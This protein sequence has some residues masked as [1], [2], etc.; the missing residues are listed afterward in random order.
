[1]LYKSWR[2]VVLLLDNT[3]TPLA[4]SVDDLADE[5]KRVL[6]EK[7]QK[8]KEL[9]EKLDQVY[10]LH[11][12]IAAELELVRHESKR[13]VESLQAVLTE[14]NANVAKAMR[15][16]G[17]TGKDLDGL[18][19]RAK[20]SREQVD[21]L[22]EERDEA[23]A[24]CNELRR[25]ADSAETAVESAQEERDLWEKQRDEARRAF[26]AC[27][28]QREANQRAAEA[29]E[30]RLAEVELERDEVRV[31]ILRIAEAVGVVHEA[32]GHNT[33]AG[34]VDE[35][36]REAKDNAGYALQYHEI[37]GEVD[38]LRQE[39]DEARAE[40]ERLRALWRKCE[41]NNR[42]FAEANVKF[43]RVLSAAR[44]VLA[45]DDAD[46]MMALQ[47]AVEA[48]DNEPV[49]AKRTCDTCK[50]RSISGEVYPCSR[51]SEM[52]YEEPVLRWEPEDR[53]TN[54]E[55]TDAPAAVREALER[56]ADRVHR[57]WQERDGGTAC[58]WDD[59]R[60]AVLGED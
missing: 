8:S 39:R 29:A 15:V 58:G 55:N 54:Q 12:A 59:L 30:K 56:A 46:S 6:D 24:A 4:S 40:A 20:W 13:K 42:D 32:D 35:I 34:P 44:Q 18:I 31:D 49:E 9:Q 3:P 38:R 37:H 5:V 17:P 21:R 52:H 43:L 25:L 11:D 53:Q 16:L 2:N 51:C 26:T 1:M 27:D 22:R 7:D 41:A 10:D 60:T 45:N 23:R 33:V 57:L 28:E 47:A 19:D 36:V 14:T 50:H 48:Y